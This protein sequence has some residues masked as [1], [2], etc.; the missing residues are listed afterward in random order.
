M[1]QLEPEDGTLQAW[2]WNELRAAIR[3]WDWL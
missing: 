2:V 3:F 1:R